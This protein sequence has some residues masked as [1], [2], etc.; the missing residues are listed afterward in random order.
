MHIYHKARCLQ[1]CISPN[2]NSSPALTI[3]DNCSA[4]EWEKF[5]SRKNIFFDILKIENLEIL[6]SN[7]FSERLQ[8][9]Q[10]GG[11]EQRDEEPGEC[12]EGSQ[13]DRGAI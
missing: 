10:H 4:A 8:Q 9:Q 3:T 13:R 11:A 7:I 6:I 5:I 1:M 12:D 2:H